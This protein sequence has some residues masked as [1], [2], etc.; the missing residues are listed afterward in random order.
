LHKSCS[1]LCC[2]LGPTRLT[3]I[4]IVVNAVIMPLVAMITLREE[5]VTSSIMLGPYIIDIVIAWQS[6][7]HSSHFTYIGLSFPST[8]LSPSISPSL[9]H[10]ILKTHLC[11]KSYHH[12]LLVPTHWTAFMDSGLLNVFLFQFVIITVLVY[13]IMH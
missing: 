3:V 7:S 1:C 5:L 2:A 10:S 11:H 13:G 4:H 6:P 8:P 12:R 9:S